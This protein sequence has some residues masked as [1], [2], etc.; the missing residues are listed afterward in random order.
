M[1]KI[2]KFTPQDIK[3]VIEIYNYYVLTSASTFDKETPSHK[4]MHA[5]FSALLDQKMP[6]LIAEKDKKVIGYAYTTPYRQR[7]GYRYSVEDSI[8]IDKD[9]IGQGVGEILLTELIKEATNLG[10]KQMIAIIGDSSNKASVSL[11]KKL[12]FNII[13]QMP[14]IGRKFNR[15]LDNIIMQKSLDK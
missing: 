2:R 7:W 6:I 15:W 14:R 8:F 12:G 9:Y 1:F 5:K 4:E 13:G 11:H 3:E 10:Y